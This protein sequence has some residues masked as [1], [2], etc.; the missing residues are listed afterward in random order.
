[1]K[2]LIELKDCEV[3]PIPPRAGRPDVFPFE[4][5]VKGFNEKYVAAKG[6]ARGRGT[7]IH[8]GY[9]FL[10]VAS[11]LRIIV[12]AWHA[13]MASFLSCVES[14]RLSLLAHSFFSLTE[15]IKPIS[16][17]TRLRFVFG[18]PSQMQQLAWV[19]CIKNNINYKT[20]IT[21]SWVARDEK[22]KA[23]MRVFKKNIA[24]LEK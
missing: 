23:E 9:C 20:K 7:C 19:A 8:G 17:A 16:Y 4:L 1:M 18:A 11:L 21:A 6:G 13:F 14:S 10:A 24:L 5:Q 3:T 22:Q 2:G 12:I 15:R